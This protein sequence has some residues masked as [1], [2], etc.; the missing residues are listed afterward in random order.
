MRATK[1]ARRIRKKSYAEWLKPLSLPIL[2]YRRLRGDVI[3]VYK[4]VNQIYDV[5]INILSAVIV[6]PADIVL[7]CK[8]KHFIIII[9]IFLNL[10]PR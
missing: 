9:I 3:E 6:P 7:N 4:I 1:M 10:Y 5:P 8:I 2:K